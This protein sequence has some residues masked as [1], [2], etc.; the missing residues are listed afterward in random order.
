LNPTR[1]VTR[2]Q[3]IIHI[4]IYLSDALQAQKEH[5]EPGIYTGQGK[6]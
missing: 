6:S 2:L 4:N 1:Y 5:I 3:F